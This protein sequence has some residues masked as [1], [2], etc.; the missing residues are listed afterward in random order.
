[1]Y[2]GYAKRVNNIIQE[3]KVKNH[4][5]DLKNNKTNGNTYKIEKN[6]YNRNTPCIFINPYA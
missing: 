2:N 3:I 6:V 1:M 5:A 4:I